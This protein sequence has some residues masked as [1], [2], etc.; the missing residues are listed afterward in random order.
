MSEC[1]F[2]FKSE[3]KHENREEQRNHGKRKNSNSE[4]VQYNKQKQMNELC[5]AHSRKRKEKKRIPWNV[6]TYV[7]TCVIKIL[8]ITG[9]NLFFSFHFFNISQASSKL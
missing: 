2:T 5:Y 3:R 4:D 6:R 7:I 8:N 1:H 9:N